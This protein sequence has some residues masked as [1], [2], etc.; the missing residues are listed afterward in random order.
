MSS[1]TELGK[2][3]GLKITIVQR[4]IKRSSPLQTLSCWSSSGF[5][6]LWYINVEVL[7]MLYIGSVSWILYHR[8]VPILVHEMGLEE[9]YR[10][11]KK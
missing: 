10:T 2:S 3:I 4:K 1:I 9:V 6:A 7:A 8:K 11:E 5:H